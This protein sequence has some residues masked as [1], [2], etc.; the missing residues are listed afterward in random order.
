VREHL[1]RSAGFELID[2][3]HDDFCG[4]A[5]T[6]FPVVTHDLR[7]KPLAASVFHDLLREPGR[8]QT[9]GLISDRVFHLGQPVAV[10]TRTALRICLSAP[11]IVDAAERFAEVR[12]FDAAMTPMRDDV[13]DLVQTWSALRDHMEPSFA[14]QA[15]FLEAS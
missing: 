3:D 2:A 15:A 7:G 1:S 8:R 10:G 6:I 11:M 12:D 13:A 5:K 14:K 4:E 9:G